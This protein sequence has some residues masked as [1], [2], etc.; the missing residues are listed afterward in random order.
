MHSMLF[1]T[2]YDKIINDIIGYR[3]YSNKRRPRLSATSRTK[4]LISAAPP[5]LNEI[6]NI[7]IFNL[8]LSSITNHNKEEFRGIPY[9]Q[10]KQ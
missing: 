3:I 4:K 2:K 7:L 6:A 5:V 10:E 9:N 8:G 1:L